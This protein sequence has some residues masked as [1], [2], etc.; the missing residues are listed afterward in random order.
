M[1]GK[2][3]AAVFITERVTTAIEKITETWERILTNPIG[4]GKYLQSKGEQESPLSYIPIVLIAGLICLFLVLKF[5]QPDLATL[6]L[7]GTLLI[8]FFLLDS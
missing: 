1:K 3:Y 2:V 7:S 8:V 6:I 4:I 5:E